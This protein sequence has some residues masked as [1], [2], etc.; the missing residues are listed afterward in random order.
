MPAGE[1]WLAQ[2]RDQTDGT[3]GLDGSHDDLG[4]PQGHGTSDGLL[5]DTG[6]HDD[7]DMGSG[8]QDTTP[9]ETGPY[10]PP[11]PTPLDDVHTDARTD[12]PPRFDQSGDVEDLWDPN[13]IRLEDHK[14]TAD[15]IT[16]LRSASLDDPIN[17]LSVRHAISP[18]T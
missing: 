7:T 18:L 4:Q 2:P 15:F 11:D 12:P 16:L 17:G 3:P 14:L 13:L 5:D 10:T 8:P 1:V 6:S 9:G